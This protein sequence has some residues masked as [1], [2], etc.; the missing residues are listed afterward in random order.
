MINLKRFE[1]VLSYF[2]KTIN[3]LI[4]QYKL[5]DFENDI[6]TK[7]W[8]L[9]KKIDISKFKD[10]KGL[11]NFIFISLKN[12]CISLYKKN[13]TYH[14]RNVLCVDTKEFNMNLLKYDDNNFSNV[15]FEEL[16]SYLTEKE[17]KIIRYKFK[18]NLSNSEIASLMKMSRQGVYKSINNSL[19]K[20]KLALD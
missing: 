2:K 13:I 14:E 12:F 20:V 15:I 4:N 11:D 9:T 5:F 10:Q 8:L 3:T 1:G 7:L 16:L 19:I 18:N 6:T 17:S